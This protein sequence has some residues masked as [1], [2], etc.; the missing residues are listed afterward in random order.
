MLCYR[1]RRR[2]AD[3]CGKR[4]SVGQQQPL[5]RTAK[6]HF[7][8][9]VFRR[10]PHRATGELHN[11]LVW[12]DDAARTT[13]IPTI[14]SQPMRPTSTV[15]PLSMLSTMATTASSGSRRP[16]CPDRPH[17]LLLRHVK[18]RDCTSNPRNWTLSPR[19]RSV[20]C[21]TPTI[22]PQQLHFWLA[23]FTSGHCQR[24]RCAAV[25]RG[26]AR[27]PGSRCRV[28]YPFAYDT[29]SQ[30]FRGHI[31]A[32]LCR[33]IRPRSGLGAPVLASWRTS[34]DLW[35][36]G[37]P[38]RGI[39]Q[40]LA[41]QIR[42]EPGVQSAVET[43]SR[44]SVPVVTSPTCSCRPHTF[45]VSPHACQSLLNAPLEDDA[46][47]RPIPGQRSICPARDGR[48]LILPAAR[49]PA[50]GTSPWL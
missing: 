48:V 32:S 36:T 12:S 8:S 34:A 22:I 50:P 41:N 37:S 2:L 15:R 1:S 39:S 25:R 28:N 5:Q 33:A 9:Y 16:R 23:E 19:R 38:V 29:E 40:S 26:A 20:G 21:A 24:M 14:P 13:L 17:R 10:H 49:S 11:R 35:T 3:H 27:L 18:S 31:C 4:A 44:G 7:I 6:V 42:E 45:W 30:K 46:A 47:A 43:L